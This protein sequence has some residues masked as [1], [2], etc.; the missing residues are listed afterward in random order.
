M[1]KHTLS[2]ILISL[3]LSACNNNE[4][5]QAWMQQVKAKAVPKAVSISPLKEY[6]LQPYNAENESNPFSMS[7]I[8]S[9]ANELPPDGRTEKEPLESVG[10]ETMNYLGSLKRQGQTIAMVQVDNKVHQ[11]KLGNHLGQ[12]YGKIVAIKDT[13]LSLRELV[14]DGEAKWSEKIVKLP[15]KTSS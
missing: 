13:E 15:I 3:M 9:T 10:L 14:R 1:K 12:N 6:I 4:D 5:L 11:V 2:L 7:R 8:G